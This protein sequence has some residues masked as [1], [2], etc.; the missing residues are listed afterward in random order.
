MED[1]I[2]TCIEI[3]QGMAGTK[4]IFSLER[5]ENK[6]NPAFAGGLPFGQLEIAYV[7]SM[8][9]EI[10]KKYKVNIK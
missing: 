1:L 3:K 8:K 6:K 10:G 5:F 2:F 9:Y 4:V 7:P